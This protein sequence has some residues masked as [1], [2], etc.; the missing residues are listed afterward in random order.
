MKS[1]KMKID[2]HQILTMNKSISREM[3]IENGRNIN[4]HRIHK[5]KGTYNRREGKKVVWE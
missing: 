2:K 5:A 3:D 1:I 4:H